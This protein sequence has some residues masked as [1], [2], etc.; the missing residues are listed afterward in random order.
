MSNSFVTLWTL[1]RCGW[2]QRVPDY[3]PLEVIFGGPHSSLPSLH[4]VLVGDTI[5]P[6]CV[7]NGELYIIARM[8]VR[9][10]T[11]PEE[12]VRNRLAIPVLG[13][14]DLCFQ[15]LKHSQPSVG[16]RVPTTCCDT[17]AVGDDG[18]E[19]CFDRRL[20]KAELAHISLG[21][22]KGREQLLKGVTEGMLR[23]SCNLQGHVRRLSTQSAMLIASTLW[24]IYLTNRYT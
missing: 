3:G 12:F 22:K 18:T 7:M 15:E 13:M 16:H 1:E 11:T 9:A 21:P 8:T 6:L 24:F 19:I 2:L 20:P 5:Y 14:W 23:N 10:L 4:K 17:A